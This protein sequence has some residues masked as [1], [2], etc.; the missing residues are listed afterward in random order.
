MR[1]KAKPTVTS[2][3]YGSSPEMASGYWATRNL[4]LEAIKVRHHAAS[5]ILK[6]LKGATVASMLVPFTSV[7]EMLIFS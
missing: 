7:S 2:L 1:T 3:I 5:V 6:F 4:S